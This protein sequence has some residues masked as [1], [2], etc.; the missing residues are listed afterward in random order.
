MNIISCD[1]GWVAG[2]KRNA[3][4]IATNDW[5]IRCLRRELDDNQLATLVKEWAT[6]ES[7]ILLDVPI[8]GCGEL[9]K[10]NPRRHV[11]NTLQHYLSLYPALKANLRGKQLREILLQGIS[12]EV[13]KN[14]I[15]KEIY[16]YAV[17][18]FL[19]FVDSKGILANVQK[20]EWQSVVD[21]NFPSKSS[22]KYKR[23]KKEERLKG[24]RYLYTFLTERLSLSFLEPLDSPNEMFS[25]SQLDLLADQYDACL[26]TVVGLLSVARNPFAW[27]IGNDDQG[28]ILMLADEW[29]KNEL[30]SKISMKRLY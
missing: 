11:E 30:E 2:K 26:G 19:W 18:K 24:M 12:Q 4:V 9:S 14:V 29:L 6:P 15:I 3:V 27:L 20:G 1:V 13:R 5:Q 7:L 22:P 23:G 21:E 17:Y 16:P 25:H 8:E 28:E 10:E